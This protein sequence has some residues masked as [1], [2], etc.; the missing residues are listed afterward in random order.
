MNIEEIATYINS[1]FF[2]NKNYKITGVASVNN[3]SENAI[4]LVSKKKY[5]TDDV[6]H[7]SGA[8]LTSPG[9]V[10]FFPR[11]NLVIS[12]NLEKDFARICS[13][14]V[15]Y[16]SIPIS[17]MDKEKKHQ[18]Y[19]GKN[20]SYGENFNYGCNVVIEDNVNI[21]N[22]VTFAHNVIICKDVKIGNN[23]VIG[24]GTII[25]SEGFGNIFD[26]KKWHHIPHLGSVKIFNNISIGANCTIDRGTIDDTIIKDGAIIDNQ[27]HIAHNVLI[28]EDTAI[29]ANVGIAGSTSIGK[30]NMIGGMVGIVDHINTT[31]DVIISATSSVFT[32]IKEPGVYTGI[33][34]IFKHTRW[35][36]IAFWISKLAKIAKVFKLKEN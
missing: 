11:N 4:V 17:S 16:S 2:G 33:M 20:V 36:R 34:P 18:I 15:N 31:D 24:P 10:N 6:I 7:K 27:V 32:D 12:D 14:F 21:G 9:F 3:P 25:G 19:I 28:G 22:D 8:I 35:K 13:L 23:V 29:A 5:I 26:D 1:T 30:R